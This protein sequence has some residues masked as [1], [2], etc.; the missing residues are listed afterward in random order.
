MSY[1]YD[2][3][4]VTFPQSRAA[5]AREMGDDGCGCGCKGKPTGCG[6]AKKSMGDWP[7]VINSGPERGV[8]D[9]QQ[10]PMYL[11]SGMP[12]TNQPRIGVGDDSSSVVPILLVGLGLVLV[13][14]LSGPSRGKS[15]GGDGGFLGGMMFA[16]LMNWR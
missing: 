1:A 4:G 14:S 10:V 15:G 5:S 8:M 2:W 12:P 13:L 9:G 11:R 3:Q 7:P 16:D 6:S